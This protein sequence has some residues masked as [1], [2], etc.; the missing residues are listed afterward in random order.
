MTSWAVISFSLASIYSFASMGTLQLVF[1]T[2]GTLG[3]SVM[4]YVP[5][6]LFHQRNLGTFA[7]DQD[8]YLYT[9]PELTPISL[10]MSGNPQHAFNIKTQ[11]Q[12]P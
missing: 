11:H 12:Y 4:L 1:C 6:K 7:S 8:D 10:S 2:G 9:I 3:L 5:G